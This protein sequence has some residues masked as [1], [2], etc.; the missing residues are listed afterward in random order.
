MNRILAGMLIPAR[1]YIHCLRVRTWGIQKI[2]ELF[3]QVDVLVSPTTTEPALK[4]EEAKE[5]EF[6]VYT[7]PAAFL[8]IPAISVPCGFSSYG[9]PVGL[10]IMAPHYR[11]ELAIRVAQAYEAVTDWQLQRPPI[12][13]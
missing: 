11:D 6:A 8:G 4:F 10:Q 1:D 5:G 13:G 2:Q 12:C 3:S 7:G 9:I